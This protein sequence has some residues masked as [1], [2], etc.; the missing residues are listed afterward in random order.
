MI[1]KSEKDYNLSISSNL[2]D[3]LKEKSHCKI[4]IT[5]R[6]DALRL[7]VRSDRNINGFVSLIDEYYLKKGFELIDGAFAFRKDY[8]LRTYKQRGINIF[9][10]I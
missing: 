1:R 5:P 4:K 8:A 10:C 6:A 7:E 9:S 3:F 2:A